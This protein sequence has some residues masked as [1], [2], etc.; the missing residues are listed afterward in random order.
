MDV[1]TI[2]DNSSLTKTTEDI[3]L[4]ATKPENLTMNSASAM[5]LEG[6]KQNQ[7]VLLQKPQITLAEPRVH[8][9]PST[10]IAVQCSP[11]LPQQAVRGHSLSLI[12]PQIIQNVRSSGP[13]T[14]NT[15]SHPNIFPVQF[16]K[17][18]TIILNAVQTQQAVT[19]KCPILPKGAS[20]EKKT[21]QQ[22]GT[23]Q[24]F[25]PISLGSGMNSSTT[26]TVRSIAPRDVTAVLQ[27][28]EA[29]KKARL[30][31][32]PM[33]RAIAPQPRQIIMSAQVSQSGSV[34]QLSR[35]NNLNSSTL[36]A[37]GNLRIQGLPG[38]VMQA[39]IAPVQMRSSL[40]QDS[41][42]QAKSNRAD[43]ETITG[44]DLVVDSKPVKKPCNCTKSQCLKL[45]C[46]CFA[47]GEFCNNCNCHNCSN[48]IN[49]EA[50]RSKAIKACLERNPYAFHPKIGKTRG[51]AERR[52][53]KGCHCK[54]SGCLKNYCECYEAKI[55][56]S[57][58]CKCTGCKNFEESPER[59]T[60][61][62]LADA[63]EVRVLQQNAAR[64]KLESQLEAATSKSASS[65]TERH[66]P[67]TFITAPVVNATCECLMARAEE[68]EINN[69][70][71]Q[72]AERMIL[73]E[74]GRSL[75]QIIQM[76]NRSKDYNA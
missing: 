50:E 63:A 75:L 21:G 8:Q 62:H 6:N 69:M 56:C 34:V 65:V 26:L 9:T 40:S 68:S 60:L 2:N 13:R 39:V 1:D 67:F 42:S 49:H 7:F 72:K 10:R 54:R 12:R 11:A 22:S 44:D 52:H 35:A 61:M 31:S 4:L 66:L 28:S 5:L 58:L 73:E 29:A 25:M 59:K 53:T 24:V 30:Q 45:Y 38:Q 64:S 27:G 23:K 18:H 74:F 14:I 46:D 43:E 33:P 57:A 47:N 19:A 76:T 51:I 3:Q 32:Q 55:M 17:G 70:S 16:S 71:E 36:H 20:P 48:N 37:L 15:I 41:V